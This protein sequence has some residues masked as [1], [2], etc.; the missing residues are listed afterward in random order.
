MPLQPRSARAL[1]YSRQQVTALLLVGAVFAQIPP[2][3]VR[4][5]NILTGSARR[6]V[7]KS[8]GSGAKH[9]DRTDSV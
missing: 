2:V 5:T 3:A 6:E 4:I 8:N 9:A 7:A 1:R